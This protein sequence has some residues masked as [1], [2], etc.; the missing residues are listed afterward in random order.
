MDNKLSMTEWCCSSKESQQ[1]AVG[2]SHKD[3]TSRGKEV[4]ISLK[5]ALVR[6]HF[7]YCVQS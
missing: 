6:L 1:D 7:E 3:T 5:L 4:I 2:C